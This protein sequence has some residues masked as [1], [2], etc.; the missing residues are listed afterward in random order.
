MLPPDKDGYLERECPHCK[1]IFAIDADDYEKRTHLNL[2]CPNCRWIERFKDYTTERQARFAKSSAQNELNRI[3]AAY[4]NDTWNEMAR[5]INRG[6]RG[7]FVNITAQEADVDLGADD[8]PSPHSGRATVDHV[9]AACGFE[10]RTEPDA[11]TA[12][13]LCR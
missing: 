12:C 3:A 1:T 11:G 8:L 6:S 4:I 13:P 9:C 10:F 7:G 5:S 2:R